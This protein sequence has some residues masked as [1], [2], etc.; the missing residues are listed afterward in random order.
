MLHKNFSIY[1][2]K[3]VD[4]IFNG[5][6]VD[7]NFLLIVKIDTLISKEKV[8]EILKDISKSILNS[9]FQNLN[10]FEYFLSSKWKE[11]NLP[12]EF[13]YAAGFLNEEKLYLKTSLRGQIFLKKGRDFAKIIE[14]ENKA[15]G[16]IEE[17]DFLVFTTSEFNKLLGGEEKLRNIFDHKNP[18]QLIEE[19]TP[20]LK[21]QE[22]NGIVALFLTFDEAEVKNIENKTEIIKPNEILKKLDQLK[23]FILNNFKL[24]LQKRPITIFIII[25]LILFLIWSLASGYNKNNL[26]NVQ[27]IKEKLKQAED[28]SELNLSRSILLLT[29]AK[30][31]VLTLKQ[32]LNKNSQTIKELES[33][34]KDYESRILKSEEKKYTEFFDLSVEDENVNILQIYKND[35]TLVLLD[36]AQKVFILSLKEKSLDSRKSSS[37]V[38]VNSIGFY[39]DDVY[40]LK[41]DGVYKLTANEKI[42]KV[43][44]N[45]K[46]GNVSDMAIFGGNIYILDSQKNDIYKY[47]PTEKSYSDK[48]SYFAKGQNIN[49]D[50]A[51]SISIDG[52]VFISF[53]ESIVKYTSGLR[54]GFSTSYP[55]ENLK[56]TKI[57]T[58]EQSDEIYAW[59]KQEGIIYIISKNG[60]YERQIKSAILKKVAD[61][62]IFEKNIYVVN[63][64]KIY[65][66]NL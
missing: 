37:L 49:L 56:L 25:I 11:Q 60:S 55:N 50:G 18:H 22:D 59:S 52:S 28:V 40:I 31:D 61:F 2:G 64:S 4:E 66:I 57:F 27:L 53:T 41:K 65:K 48:I 26:K 63:G 21:S 20:K 38:N 10:D 6:I 51:K 24:K 44:S 30:K 35:D 46:W 39:Q 62:V 9:N 29:D 34:I 12:A 19:I 42:N 36:K 58:D 13:S 32:K 7:D 15:S 54:D 43:I 33:L 45:D 8:R 1:L 23:L 47:I 3:E 14:G 16:I 5:F 17:G